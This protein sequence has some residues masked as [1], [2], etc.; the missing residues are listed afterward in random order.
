MISIIKLIDGTE[1]IGKISSEDDINI[2]VQDPMQII[3]K[4][5]ADVTMPVISMHRFVPFAKEHVHTIKS[6]HVLVKT[7]PMNGLE[8]YY[9]TLVKNMIEDRIDQS[10]D[11]EFRSAAQEELTDE[12]KI[13][14]AMMEKM[15]SKATLN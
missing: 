4:Y 12:M 9:S 1:I 13:K 8:T 15:S 2:T 6:N 7:P 14:L 5:R 3:Q 10:V 11:A